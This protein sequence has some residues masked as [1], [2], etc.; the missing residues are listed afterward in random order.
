M[1]VIVI[2][3]YRQTISAYPSGGGSYIVA[4]DNLGPLPG[5][6]AGAS[7]LTDYV[8]TVAVSIAAGV[9]ALTSIFPVLFHDRVE[10]AVLFVLLICLG[11]L[12]GIRESGTIFAS[13]AYIYLVAIV[14][15]LGYGLFRYFT[16]TLPAYTPPPAWQHMEGTHALGLLLI[17]RAFSSGSVALTG[18]EAVSN[19]VPA[20][21]P[22]ETKH[23]QRVLLLMGASF[24]DDLHRHELPRRGSSASFRIPTEQTTVVSQLAA[25]SSGTARRTTTSCRS[26]RRCCS[27]SRR[28]PAFADFPRLSSILARDGTGRASSSTAATGSRSARASSCSPRSSIA[29]ADRVPRQC[30]EPHPAVHGRRLH[31]VHAEPDRHGPSLVAPPRRRSPAGGAALL[32][33][34]IGAVATGVVAVIVGLSKFGSARGWCS[35]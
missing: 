10:L 6:V 14:G 3:S 20:F 11:N 22:P 15:L 19:G 12:R 1:L 8:L 26:R 4:S 16:G 23:A 13:P 2:T 18:V 35:C 32:V 31:R 24:G 25:R 17:L 30:H 21:A 28:T 5:L 29:A 9:A 34:G 27:S 7:L 33:N